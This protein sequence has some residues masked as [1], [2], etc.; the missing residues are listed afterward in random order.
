MPTNRHTTVQVGLPDVDWQVFYDK[1]GSLRQTHSGL[2]KR[3]YRRRLTATGSAP[4]VTAIEA[5]A[6]FQF[7]AEVDGS[8]TTWV[9]NGS[10]IPGYYRRLPEV[11]GYYAWRA[12]PQQDGRYEVDL[13]VLRRPRSL[14]NDYEIGRAHV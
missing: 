12:T 4:L 11:H 1:A 9:D 7:I 13:R 3:I 5:P 10:V 14:A 6:V 2:R 8:T